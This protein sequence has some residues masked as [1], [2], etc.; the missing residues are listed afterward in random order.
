MLKRFIRHD[1]TW[2]GTLALA[3]AEHHAMDLGFVTCPVTLVAG[4]HDVL[5]SMHD[6]IECAEAIP[7]AEVTVLPGSHFLPL[8][9]PDL[10]RVALGELR[11]R[12]LEPVT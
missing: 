10:L 3:A 12:S 1:W 7:H 6:V 5:T 2:Y 4:Q 8:E 11:R 9:Y